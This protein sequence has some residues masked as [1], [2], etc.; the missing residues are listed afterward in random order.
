M[1]VVFSPEIDSLGTGTFDAVSKSCN[2]T[3]CHGY[4]PQGDSAIVSES[5]SIGMRCSACHNLAL[6]KREG[7]KGHTTVLTINNVLFSND[8]CGFCHAGYNV[9]AGRINDST[10]CDGK[11][12]TFNCTKCPH[13]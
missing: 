9:N 8:N 2:A 5:D 11:V 10:H 12:Q 4:F 7:H 13:R 1:D 6:M 3:Y